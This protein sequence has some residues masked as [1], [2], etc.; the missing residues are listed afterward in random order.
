MHT[1]ASPVVRVKAEVGATAAVL[2]LRVSWRK[3]TAGTPSFLAKVENRNTSSVIHRPLT[4]THEAVRLLLPQKV[5]AQKTRYC[6]LFDTQCSDVSVRVHRC[7]NN[8]W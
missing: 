2:P 6:F 7:V 4:T 1:I 8:L 3:V 5:N